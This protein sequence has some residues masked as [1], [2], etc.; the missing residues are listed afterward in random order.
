MNIEE[1]LIKPVLLKSKARMM[2]CVSY[3]TSFRLKSSDRDWMCWMI[4]LKEVITDVFQSRVT[5][6]MILIQL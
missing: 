6:D 1:V 3:R 2:V 4:N 5:F